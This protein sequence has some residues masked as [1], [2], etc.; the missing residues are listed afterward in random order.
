MHV[1]KRIASHLQKCYSWDNLMKGDVNS[2]D[3][4]VG[5]APAL[6]GTKDFTTCLHHLARSL[7]FRKDE[8][9]RE[10]LLSASKQ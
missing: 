1:D 10:E 9:G 2:S 3:P 8:S 6:F 5:Q 4:V 7:D